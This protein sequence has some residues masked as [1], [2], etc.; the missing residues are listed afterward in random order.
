MF[1]KK[2]KRKSSRNRETESSN[3]PSQPKKRK[4]LP[5]EV[6]LMVVEAMDSGLGAKDVAEIVE[7]SSHTVSSWFRTW[8]SKGLDGT[9]IGKLSP[10]A[11]YGRPACCKLS[12][13]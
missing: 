9:G 13:R 2:K 3:K 1:F 4:L 11:R 10:A 6:K 7:V 12:H 8:K 5:L